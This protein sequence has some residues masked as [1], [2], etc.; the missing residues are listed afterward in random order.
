MTRLYWWGLAALWIICA[1]AAWLYAS[2]YG[3]P[4]SLALALLPAFLLEA[5]FYLILGTES[6]RVKI[7]RLLPP[8]GLAAALA[9]SA[10]A[11][12]LAAAL[13]IHRFDWR[14][15]ALLLLL[16]LAAAFWY[17]V[18]PHAA[19]ADLAFVALAAA[20][21]AAKVFG[22]LYP[23]PHPKVPLAILGQLALIRTGVF[24]LLH[25]RG[26]KIGF[27]FIPGRRD[28][29]IGFLYFLLF[30]P[31]AFFLAPALGFAELRM[32]RAAWWRVAIAAGGTFAGILWVVALSEE[33][34]FRGLLQTWIGQWTRKPWLGLLAA[35]FLFGAVHLGFRE[36]PNWKFSALA[37]C[38]GVFYGLAFRATGSIRTSMVTHA[39]VVTAWR[40]FFA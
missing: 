30:L 9:A 38:A 19:A 14:S 35:S 11:P 34:L 5:K 32:P 27:G 16:F 22:G 3:I 26:M 23:E 2:E 15:F 1:L 18:L 13:A 8:A 21:M 20:V 25:L 12:Y 29:K 24:A 33:F 36:F 17:V 10:L 39:L 4:H 28:W 31:I 6:A 37:A 7:A 40:T